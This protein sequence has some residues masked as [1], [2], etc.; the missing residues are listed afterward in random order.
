MDMELMVMEVWQR[1]RQMERQHI[2]QLHEQP[3]YGPAVEDTD[4]ED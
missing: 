3:T 2:R 4:D 1:V